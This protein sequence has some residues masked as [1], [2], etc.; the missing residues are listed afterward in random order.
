[1]RITYYYRQSLL[2]TPD[3]QA[4]HQQICG[5]L[6]QMQA[7]GIDC[8]LDDAEKAFPTQDAQQ[9]L[10]NQL[11]DFAARHKVGLART[12]GSRRYGFCYLPTQFLL[13][14]E[15]GALR[16]VFP[17]K[18]GDGEVDPVE[19]LEHVAA[20]RPWTIRSG[21]GMEGKQHKVVV[22]RI[23]ADS[24][25]LEPDLVLKGQNVQVSQDF[26]ELGF[27]DL[28]YEDR[29]GRPLLIEVKVGPDELD[30]AVGQI[31]RHRELYSRQNAINAEKIRLGIACPFIP[32]QYRTIC[33]PIGIA[34]FELGVLPGSVQAGPS[35][36]KT[37]ISSSTDTS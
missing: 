12:F 1:M 24:S 33:R 22:A 36:S 13:L 8:A 3:C 11:R 9:M 32:A 4:I 34:C 19:Y 30:K 10:F 31:L 21:G 29:D 25:V 2:G 20:G 18:M 37:S 7:R 28:V 14:R 26:G 17:C 15:G 6:A 23:V 5:L 27:I 35:I 16:E